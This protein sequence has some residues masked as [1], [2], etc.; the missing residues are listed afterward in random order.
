M[1][2]YPSLFQKSEYYLSKGYSLSLNVKWHGYIL[3]IKHCHQSS[4][5]TKNVRDPNL[6]MK[7]SDFHILVTNSQIRMIFLMIFFLKL[8]FIHL[9]STAIKL[10]FIF[11]KKIIQISINGSDF[12]SQPKMSGFLQNDVWD[13]R[14]QDPN[15]LE[16]WICHNMGDF[17]TGYTFY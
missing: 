4:K 15:F 1:V 8:L 9:W 11:S 7:M 16:L 3:E 17:V 5:K 13:P 10:S 2:A 14:S 12:W 6:G